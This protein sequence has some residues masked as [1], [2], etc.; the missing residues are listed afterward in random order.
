GAAGARPRPLPLRPGR[1]GVA[2]ASRRVFTLHRR[3]LA[4]PLQALGAGDPLLVPDGERH[5]SAAT[6]QR[7]YDGLVARRFPRDGLLLVLGGGVVGDLAGYAAATYMRG[8]D[9]AVV[10]TT[11]LAM[12]DSSIGGKVGLNHARG[13]NLIG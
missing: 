12:V 5:K 11:L 4:K 2:G 10:P 8:V 3:A 9:W 13:K 1:T 6:L 7:I